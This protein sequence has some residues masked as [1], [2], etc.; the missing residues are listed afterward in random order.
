MAM[1]RLNGW[2]VP[3]HVA[4]LVLVFLGERVFA[5]IDLARWA[6]TGG[7]LML[8]FA[9]TAVRFVGARSF[10]PE[11]GGRARQ[12]IERTLGLLSG[13]GVLALALYFAISTEKG[14][15][16]LG[17]A[18]ASTE[19]RARLDAAAVVVWVA[20]LVVSLPA[21]LLGESALRPMRRARAI[22]GRRVLSA[23]LAGLTLGVA[24]LY[25]TLTT[26]AVSEL[27]VKADY[28]YFR[29]ARPGES[30]TK[31][32]ANLDELVQVLVFFPELNEVGLEVGGYVD[33]LR[34]SA[35][36]LQIDKYDRLLVPAIAK[37]A[38][39]T[40]EG[41]IVLSRGDARETLV[42]GADPKLAASKLKTLDADFQK[43]LLK[44]VRPQRN[45]YL[46]VGHGELNET[47][48][49]KEGRTGKSI[50]KLL[51]SQNYAV[52]DL[53]LGQGL[54]S[55]IPDDATMV[56][57]LGPT[58]ALLA[59]EVAALGRYAERGGKLLFALDPEAK[60]D[61]SPL[62]ELVG[63]TMG[64]SVLANDKAPFHV[65][66]RGNDSDRAILVSNRFSSHAS[67][68]TLSRNAQRAAVIFPGAAALEKR[69]G[70]A[71]TID[72]AVRSL[73]DTFP[74]DN[75]DFQFN[76]GSEKRSVYNLAAAITR[77]GDAKGESM[78]AFVIGDADAFSD[79]ALGNEA[80]AI[81]LL[82]AMRWLGGEE[83]FSGAIE[84][85]EDVRIEHTKQ[86]DLVWFY[87]ILFGGPG[88]VLGA[89]LLLSRRRP[90]A[91]SAK[92]RAS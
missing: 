52:K 24:A 2:L 85:T 3:A 55:A 48:D 15:A 72:F 25:V 46:T 50:R 73:N 87:G 19:L 45:A 70:T 69:E 91:A 17:L 63:L 51:E 90:S 79:A 14:R 42:L 26:F 35:P 92:E 27:D 20:L 13:L 81:F 80:N 84:T 36:K 57:A 77:A 11:L 58:K 68:S 40:Q 89:G 44:V 54:G 18:S 37:D 86:K 53:G 59:E 22:E 47:T 12:R 61:F 76:E 65:R 75:G 1:R 8:A 43:A 38:K 71:L 31:I 66:R 6:L 10:G 29:T 67:V 88:L 74:D 4:G 39:V 9:A 33:E 62:T 64:T 30:T 34:K 21:L 5:G 82:D 78:R 32:A 23:T 56:I 49:A 16:L 41:V 60:V 83:S 7:G 28:S